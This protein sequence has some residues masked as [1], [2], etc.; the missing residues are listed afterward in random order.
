MLIYFV[1]F[2]W[3]EVQL[4][5]IGTWSFYVYLF[6]LLYALLLYLLASL[7]FPNDMPDYADYKIYFNSRKAWFFAILALTDGVD[8]IDT[9]LKER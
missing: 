3:W 8:F 6:L 7:L 1:E 5:A 4:V 9:W 2:W